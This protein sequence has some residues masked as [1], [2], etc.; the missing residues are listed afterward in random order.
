MKQ[1]VVDAV[2]ELV[3][4]LPDS[5]VTAVEDS[6]GGAFVLVEPIDVGSRFAPSET[7]VGFHITFSYPE[8]D[9]YPHFIDA[10]VKYVG[11]GPTPNQHP[12]GDLPTALSRGQA[13]P[14]FD[15][16]AIQISRRSKNPGTALYK[17]RRVI[18]FLKT[19]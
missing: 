15:R 8:A 9:V 19:R 11:E 4:G 7:W 18:D 12:D 14:H 5:T 3:E 1:A 2:K 6:D 13:L 16:A 17:L 10:G